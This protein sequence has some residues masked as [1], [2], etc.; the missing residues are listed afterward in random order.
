MTGPETG[1]WRSSGTPVH[2][3]KGVLL[4]VAAL[5]YHVVTLQWLRA[6]RWKNKDE[7]RGELHRLVSEREAHGYSYWTARIGKAE[8]LEFTTAQGTWYQASVE[9]V[10][11]DQPGG[12]VRVLFALDDGGVGAFHPLTDSLLIDKPSTPE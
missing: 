10:W 11:D 8:R 1:E 6:P 7:A 3:V 5:A 4:A 12:L 9:P 2:G